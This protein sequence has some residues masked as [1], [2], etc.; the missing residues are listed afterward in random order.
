[1][2][3]SGH[4]KLPDNI[5]ALSILTVITTICYVAMG[6]IF[7][8]MVVPNGSNVVI[9]IVNYGAEAMVMSLPLWIL[10]GRW[11][12]I[13]PLLIWVCGLFLLANAVYF[14]FRHDL[15]P[16]TLIFN[17][18]SYNSLV[19]NSGL[20][21][22]GVLDCVFLLF[23]A[24]TTAAYF[25][26]KIPSRPYPGKKTVLAA[27]IAAVC[28]LPT[29]Y[30]LVSLS[31]MRFHAKQGRNL[32]LAECFNKKTGNAH[33]RYHSW[34]RNGLFLYFYYEFTCRTR[35]KITLDQEQRA[36]IESYLASM[37]APK[38]DN[39]G[40]FAANRD[41]N[42]IFIVV[43]SLN[44]W[45]VGQQCGG[46][47]LTPVLDSL[48]NTPG[49]ISCLKV[50]S[51]ARN[52]VSSDGQLIYNTGLLP[53][54]DGV[55]AMN[56]GL[57]TY[58]SLANALNSRRAEEFIVEGGAL[59]NHYT[60]TVSY[61]Y[62][63][64]NDEIAVEGLSMDRRV[65]KTALDSVAM[66]PQPF[67]A[68][69]TT[70]SMHHP[71]D[72]PSVPVLPAVE[73]L[74]EEPLRK[75]YLNA[76]A[77]FDNA[78]G[79]FIESLKDKGLFDNSVIILASDHDY[80]TSKAEAADNQPLSIVFMALNTGLSR[81]IE[82]A[83]GQVDVFP[84]VLE[85]MNRRDGWQGLGVSMLDTVRPTPA[86]VEEAFRVSDLIIRSDYFRK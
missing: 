40:I 4:I 36:A 24:V 33:F 49:T 35:L 22:M 71:F 59:W 73:A 78:L 64:L 63:R 30:L 10:P 76:V 37:P 6:C 50:S 19:F 86:R 12:I 82:Y 74:D 84:T 21:M 70:M 1:M 52:G 55:T 54:H 34:N 38:A 26:L 16:L 58:P 83:A 57:N 72:D 65:F 27:C 80:F 14:K 61:G 32:T 62:D 47:T 25:M 56:F 68:E 48:I 75:G 13:T 85:I 3:R 46:R 15:I 79:W 20:H 53:I 23:P 44:A 60:T 51:Q 28:A 81:R 8:P 18:Q 66:M 11:R 77:E 43:E 45:V 69:I 42:L 31:V 41:K 67:F 17:A 7:D 9:S 2:P 5:R 29:A 39:A